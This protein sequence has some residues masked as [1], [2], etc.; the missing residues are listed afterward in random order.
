MEEEYIKSPKG[1][2]LDRLRVWASEHRISLYGKVKEKFSA[3]QNNVGYMQFGSTR[4]SSKLYLVDN[5]GI[6]VWRGIRNGWDK[7]V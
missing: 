6:Y 1:K 3:D 2:K 5:D 4:K 7:L